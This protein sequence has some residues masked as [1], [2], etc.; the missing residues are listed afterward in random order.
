MSSIKSFFSFTRREQYGIMVLLF[1]IVATIA[2]N[3]FIRQKPPP[4]TDKETFSQWAEEVKAF[5]EREE[6]AAQYNDSLR[7]ARQQ[8]S[9]YH[10]DYQ[11]SST[12]FHEK[13]QKTEKKFPD[14]FPFNPNDADKDDFIN[15]GFS[16]KQ[17]ESIVKYR[18]K[19]AV[20]KSKQDFKKV[21]VVS[22]EMYAHLETW[23]SL[24]DEDIADNKT[25][26]SATQENI[27]VELNTADTTSLKQIKH[28]GSHFAKRI[29]EYRQ[30]LGGFHSVE[31]LLDINGINEEIY[32][33]IAPY[34]VVDKGKIIKLD[35]NKSSFKDFTRHPYFEYY[36][37]KS[38]FEYKDKHGVFA[39]VNDI[40]EIPLIYDDLYNKI[41]PY[42]YVSA[43]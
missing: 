13:Y 11:K 36:I 31:Q 37:V 21:F 29:V 19:G 34:F 41:N 33:K 16:E 1:L 2:I 17:A 40:R 38:L 30:K 5:Q 3:F 15:L 8:R 14:S 4:L 28:I 24:P 22:D 9:N 20:F 35:L 18:D 10:N 12:N 23:I 6:I 32:S 43:N 39:S 26:T 25:T 42:L 7:M 27:I